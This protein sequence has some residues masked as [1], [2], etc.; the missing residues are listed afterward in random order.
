MKP[1]EL[2]KELKSALLRHL[3]EEELLFHI[4]GKLDEIRRS[5]IEVHLKTCRLCQSRLE[6]SREVDASMET[7]EISD[8]DAKLAK[9]LLS[10]HRPF[11]KVRLAANALSLKRLTESL[12]QL[13]SSWQLRFDRVPTRGGQES[14]KFWEWQSED[15]ILKADGVMR[16]DGT[17]VI[18][19]SSADVALDGVS[20]NFHL[21]PLEKKI[22]L[23]KKS[24][25]LVVAT[26]EVLKNQRAKNLSD[27]SIEIAIDGGTS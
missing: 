18:E 3:T 21:G 5:R 19:V 11:G 25:S 9:Q 20:L 6:L 15:K 7:R 22:T 16:K 17:I 2:E 1:D 12:T 4:K 10:E 14:E 8:E 23:R 27:L 13:V 24:D 26:V